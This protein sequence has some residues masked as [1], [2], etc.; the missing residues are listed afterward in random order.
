MAPDRVDVLVV[1]AG[2][3]GATLALQAADHGATVRVVER[4]VEPFRPSRALI[5]HP[6]TLEVLRPLGVS[7]AVLDR[8]DASPAARL[9]LRSGVVRADL[10]AFDL[11]DS[12][13]PHLVLIRQADVEAALADALSDRG[14]GI[15]RGVE[16]M[17]L[18]RRDGSVQATTRGHGEITARYVVGCDGPASVVRRS[19][20]TGWAGR[21]YRQEVV[22][23]DVE[24]DG[25]L[26][27]GVVHAAPGPR[28]LVFL[29]S[30]GE[31]A[32]WRL[33]AT[34]RVPPGPPGAPFGQPGPA[35]PTDDLQILLAPSGL[36]VRLRDAPWSARVPLQH[37]LAGRF[38]SGAVFVAGDAA[39]TH[40]PAGGQGMNTGI[41]DATNL[42][43]KLALAARD[44]PGGDPRGPDGDALL[45]SYERERRPVARQVLAMTRLIFWAEASTGPVARAA[46]SIVSALGAPALPVLLRRRR[47]LAE[48]VRTLGQL[49]VGYRHSPLSVTGKR[50][51]RGLPR[52]G[53]RLGDATVVAGTGPVRLHDLT[54]P[55]GIHVLVPRDGRLPELD[56]VPGLVH[57]HRLADIPGTGVVAVRPDGYVGFSGDS[58]EERELR[59]WLALVHARRVAAGDMT[60][61][62]D[63]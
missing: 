13:F 38:R 30:L 22:L 2:P 17:G 27:P 16:V 53:R 1:G 7:E 61:A 45:D 4:R 46:R 12:P 14:I 3:T 48:G 56:A 62:R 58:S 8:G 26:E 63:G 54:A 9:H 24:I 49:R 42:G 10:D 6:R 60:V 33:L 59:A 47:L 35:V 57:T 25:D 31:H 11:P 19:L 41:Q 37:R 34:R 28:G 43:W 39:H 50:P 20:G 40:S 51:A 32:T 15:E 36:G 5:M 52:A 55:P 44:R 18:T 21:P 29:F 23:A